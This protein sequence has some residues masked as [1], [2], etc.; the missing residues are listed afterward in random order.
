MSRVLRNKLLSQAL[1][2]SSQ[3]VFPLI[4]YP[5]VTRALGAQ[6][7]G[8]VNF[9]DSLMQVLLMIASLGIP[10]HGAREIAIK[11]NNGHA[12]AQTF[13]ELFLLQVIVLVPAGI[14]FMGVGWASH[15]DTRLLWTGL[16]ALAGNALSCDWYFQGN[17]R[18]F[19]I[20]IRS[21]IVRAL[22]ALLIVLLVKQVGDMVLYYAILVGSVVLTMLLNLATIISRGGLQ[23]KKPQPFRQLRNTGWLYACYVLASLYTVSDTLLLGWLSSDRAVG[24]FSIGY[25]LVRMS[26]MLIATMGVVFVPRISFHHAEKNDQAVR[27]KIDTSQSLIFFLALPLSLFFFLMA[28]ELIAVFAHNGFTPSIN[29]IRILSLIP[30]LVSFSHLTGS[31]VLIPVRKEKIY[32]YFLII[33]CVINFSLDLLLIPAMQER[34]TAVS[35]LVTEGFVA[36]GSGLYLYNLRLLRVSWASFFSSLGA[37]LVLWPVLYGFRLLAVSPLVVMVGTLAVSALLY[38][39][40]QLKLFRHPAAKLLFGKSLNPA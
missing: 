3:L 23:F 38:L 28:P 25:K 11:R 20:A 29:V 18:F 37:S 10:L 1:L 36:I 27:E 13:S 33:G 21:V 22:A 4:T 6:A 26:A 14:C 34:A 9:T 5:V 17:E 15:A 35:N 16:I 32:F 30:L 24:Y 40:I 7:L 19:F 12:Q 39:A 8:Q 2:A 31:Q